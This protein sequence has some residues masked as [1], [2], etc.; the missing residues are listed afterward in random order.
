[1]FPDDKLHEEC[2]IFGIYA[3][4]AEV[5]RYTFFALYALQHRGQ[6]AAGIVTSDGKVAHVHKGMGL[7]S[8]VFDEDNL[9]YLLGHLAIGHTRY[10]TTG[11]PK[12]RNTQPYVIETLDGPL[13]I[14]HNGNLINAPQLRRELLERGVGLSTSSDS[15][16]ILHLL[17]GSGGDWLARI[18]IVM[19]RAEGAY[20]LVILTRD[21][22]Y[23][24]RDPWGLRPLVLGKLAGGGH[25]LASESCAFA[26]IGAEL[27][28]EIQP[29]EVVRIDANGYDIVQGAPPQPLAF[30]TF[31]QIYFARPDSLL[32]GKLVHQTRQKLGKQL[33]KESPAHADIVVP[34]PDS[35][36]PHAIGYAQKS[37]IPYSEG[38]IKSRY[39]GRTFIQPSNELRR[40]GVAMKFNPLPENLKG[41]RVVLVDD[42][43][44]RGNTSGPLVK[45]LRDAGAKEVHVRVACPPIKFPCFMG[46]DM[47]SQDELISANKSVDEICEHIGADSLAF[48]TI[49]GMM[50][51]LKAESGYCNAC[52]T[53]DYPF[54]TPI[55]LI[56]L[57]EKEKFA[58]VWG[59]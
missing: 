53:G 29:G 31:E 16:V 45:M 43:I 22:V 8:Q 59:D 13:A 40:V 54:S 39:I 1:M 36:T 26:T 15:E 11:S 24:V 9:R 3:S 28:R 37:G 5:A 12:L 2:G 7:V 56:E 25:V 14:G 34:V 6:E 42:S 10:S 19:A 48:L 49:S 47:A 41:K 52:F 46:V 57:Q 20:A 55:P 18:R 50:R 58:N 4:G 35:G 21:A 32:N 51:A 30:C 33:A 38:L 17:A 44:V 23:G 27:V